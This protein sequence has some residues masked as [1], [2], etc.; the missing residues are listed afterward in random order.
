MAIAVIVEREENSMHI[1][2]L[3]VDPDYS[4]KRKKTYTICF[5]PF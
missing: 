4:W 1:Q 3:V 2:S 5:K